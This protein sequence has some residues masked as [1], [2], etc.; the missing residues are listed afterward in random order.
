MG[1]L[2]QGNGNIIQQILGNVIHVFKKKRSPCS[3]LCDGRIMKLHY[4]FTFYIFL[5]GFSAVWFSW[6]YSNVITCT[7]KFNAETQVRLDYIN[8]CL[9][10]PYLPSGIE[11]RTYLLFYRWIHWTLLVIALLFY[12]PRKISKYCDNP[13][14][15]KLIEDM[16][17]QS[18]R[19]DH[20]EK[21]LVDRATIYIAFNLRT[22][23][24]L[25]FKYLLCNILALVIDGVCFYALDVL[26]HGRFFSYGASALTRD[27]YSFTDYISRTFPPF[28]ECEISPVNELVAKRT[29]KFGCHLQIMELYEKLFF[30]IWYWLIFVMICTCF[31]IA[32]LGFLWLPYFRLM[33]LKVPKPAHAKT[34]VTDTVMS[35]ISFCKIGDIYLLYRL[36]QYCSASMYYDLLSSLSDA[37]M[38][39]IL[40]KHPDGRGSVED[41]KARKGKANKGLKGNFSNSDELFIPTKPIP[42]KSFLI[43]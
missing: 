4:Q 34:S 12:I 7:S 5:I 21:E 20:T 37:D 22:H 2:G 32:F 40:R 28:V 6:Y 11:D 31:Y 36:K 42:N 29:E 17:I 3:S 19:Y 24:G 23:N 14:L 16:A 38:L 9:S 27:P 43:E 18:Y 39:R 41:H 1:I 15:K 30:F 25:Y 26:F 8:I 35:V 33:L 13:K 10:Y